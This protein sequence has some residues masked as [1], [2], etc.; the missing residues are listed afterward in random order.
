[1]AKEVQALYVERCDGKVRLI[2][3]PDSTLWAEYAL[4][5]A[6]L[7]KAASAGVGLSGSGG[8]LKAWKCRCRGRCESSVVDLCTIDR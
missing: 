2:P 4:R 3:E 6:A 1:M 7:L 8:L 5:S